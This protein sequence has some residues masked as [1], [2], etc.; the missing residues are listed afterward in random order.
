MVTKKAALSTLII[1]VIYVVLTILMMNGELVKQTILGN[2]PLDYKF[3]LLVAL[4]T[5]VSTSMTELGLFLLFITAILTGINVTLLFKKISQLKSS[6]KLHLV[7]GGSSFIGIIGSGCAACGLPI[8]SFFG[9]AGSIG[10]LPFHG[11]ELSLIAI[12]MLS[13][14]LYLINKNIKENNFCELK[15]SKVS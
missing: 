5:G 7:V 15:V 3:N 14:S 4:I 12:A 6:G 13:F 2:F 8:L 10:F 1:V 11:S 9:L